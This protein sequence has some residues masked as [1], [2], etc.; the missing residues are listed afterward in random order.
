M[1]NSKSI[2]RTLAAAT[3]M[4]VA[5]QASAHGV[6]TA[7]TAVPGISSGGSAVLTINCPH[8]HYAIAGGY[9]NDESLNPNSMLVVTGSY[10]ASTRSWAVEF[11]NRSGRPTVASEAEVVLYVTCDHHW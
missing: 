4:V 11:T 9:Q 10:P 7:T 2:L 3:A 6:V 1:N 5:S 8:H